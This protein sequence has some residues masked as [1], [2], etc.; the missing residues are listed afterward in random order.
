MNKLDLD[1]ILED[2]AASRWEMA[3][4]L[5][6]MYVQAGLMSDV[7]VTRD[8]R[9]GGFDPSFINTLQ[10]EVPLVVVEVDGVDYLCFPYMREELG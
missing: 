10:T 8:K 4:L 5:Q 1:E 6:K 9:S 3:V 7:V 2:K